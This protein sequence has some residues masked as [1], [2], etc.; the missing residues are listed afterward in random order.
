MNLNRSFVVLLSEEGKETILCSNVHKEGDL[1]TLPECIS[2][3]NKHRDL[4]PNCEYSIG[5][6]YL[7]P[8]KVVGTLSGTFKE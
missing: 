7:V 3:L 4:F 2:F 8:Q 5:K 1:G 6:V